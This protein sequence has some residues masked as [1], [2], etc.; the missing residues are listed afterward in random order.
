MPNVM[1]VLK[2][3]IQR[4]ARKEASGLVRRL[5]ADTVW[6]K[7][8]AAQ[9][10]RQIAAMQSE[11]RRLSVVARPLVAATAEPTPDE[12][13]SARISSGMVK[14]VRAKLGVSQAQLATLVGVNPV[15][16]YMWERKEGRL[17]LRSAARAAFLAVRKLGKREV[18]ARLQKLAEEAPAPRRRKPGRKPGRRGGK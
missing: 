5:R 10:K 15:S 11:L 7:S 18:K 14:R 12:M 17:A 1:S 6:L 13:N 2:A 4:L 16:V 8:R 3:E 9:Q